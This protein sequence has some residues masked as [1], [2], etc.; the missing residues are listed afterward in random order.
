MVSVIVPNHNRDLT[1]L[2]NSLPKG[3]EF[4]E[5]NLGL[6]RSIQR[7][8]GIKQAKGK[9]IL[10]LDSDQSIS[11]CLIDKCVKLMEM[12]YSAIYIPEIIVVKSFFGK[13]RKFEREFYVGTAI[14]CVRFLRKDICPLFDETLN[15]PEDSDFDR[16]VPGFRAIAKN[17]L[18]HHDDIGFLEYCRKKAYYTKSMKRFAEKWPNDKCLNIWWRCFGVFVEKG[19]WKKLLRHPVLSIGILFILLVRGVIYYVNK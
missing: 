17:V 1:I 9:Y 15:G 13:I 3:V 4:I 5:V 10:W 6:E 11:Y 7:N 18:Y 8:I 14:D 16:R 12:G 2:K 19:K